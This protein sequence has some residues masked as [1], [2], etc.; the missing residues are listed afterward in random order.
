MLC[1][2]QKEQLIA[3]VHN[4]SQ[5]DTYYTVRSFKG[6]QKGGV[7]GTWKGFPVT[8]VDPAGLFGAG[9]QPA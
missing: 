5:S 7:L 1:R 2:V 4:C 3:S 8:S 6:F 9:V